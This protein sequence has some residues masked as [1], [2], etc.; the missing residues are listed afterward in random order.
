MQQYTFEIPETKEANLLLNFILATGLFNQIEH[1]KSK[2]PNK[3]T[4]EAIESVERREVNKY[5][6][7]ND[8][9][10]QL[11]KIDKEEMVDYILSKL[12]EIDKSNET[13]SETEILNTLRA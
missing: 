13:V 10:A 6:N 3:E 9:I 8:L 12:M 2:I 4:I 5:K 7:V 11:E 1:Y